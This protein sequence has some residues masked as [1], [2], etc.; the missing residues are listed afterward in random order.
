[1]PWDVIQECDI[2]AIAFGKSPFL[3]INYDNELDDAIAA[4]VDDIENG[5]FFVCYKHH[6]EDNVEKTSTKNLNC[7]FL[8]SPW[9]LPNRF[10][11]FSADF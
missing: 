7:A 2:I 11:T 10:L 4:L 9:K 3:H 5:D 6:K 1:M 8:T